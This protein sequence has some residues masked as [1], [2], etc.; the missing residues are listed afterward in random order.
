MDNKIKEKIEKSYNSI[1]V[2]AA[3][4]IVLATIIGSVAINQK[5]SYPF[6]E[7]KKSDISQ[8]ISTTGTVKSDQNVSLSFKKG[9]TI[10]SIKV[11]T[12]NKVTK[13]Q[14]LVVLDSKD[15]LTA[16]SQA[17]AALD[18]AKASY[19]KVS[20][21]A[22]ANSIAVAQSAVDSTQVSLDNVKSISQKNIDSKYDYALT[23]LDDANIKMYNASIAAKNIQ[24]NYFTGYDQD[25]ANVRNSIDAI[26]SA[27]N[28]AK[29]SIDLAQSTK[30]KEDIDS[31]IT[32]TKKSLDKI[33]TGLTT[34]KNSCDGTAYK[35]IVSSTEK[36]SLD[37]QKSYISTLQITVS[38][39][40]N[41]IST[42]KTQSEN[43]I[44]SAEAALSQAQASL[45]NLQS[46]AR[47]EDI[48]A[49]KATVEAAE[50]NLRTAQNAYSDSMIISPIDGVITNINPKIGEVVGAGTT[51]VSMISNNKFQIETYL[52]QTELGKIKVGDAV[53]ATLD[54][55]G[56]DVIFD[57]TI[58]TIDPAATISS[59]ISSYKVA[60]EISND[61][62]R[63]K[64]GLTANITIF[65]EKAE[66][67]ITVPLTS[68]LKENGQNYVLLKNKNKI[69]LKKV[70][71][72]LSD[73]QR[74]QITS[75]LS[76]GENILTFEK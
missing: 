33:L 4:L 65:D 52:S 55:Y 21:G 15:T 28:S 22:T 56:K 69:E 19:E 18:S 41:E 31:A 10:A 44:K 1:L 37:T 48:A 23:V 29:T 26:E 8:S 14:T 76:E 64:P 66:N 75:G 12:G 43:N 36:T 9:G 59:G 53:K 35:N 25:A 74:I 61:D 70:E 71:T 62:E 73:G 47:P 7:I 16:V 11:K 39:L 58:I 63:I 27:K 68:L 5:P 3:S 6:S 30:K 17:T 54:A 32:E 72:G 57:A 67:A 38:S 60:A 20:N 13:G 42:L 46:P 45:T 2:G 51:I 40:E 34:I 49:T 24:T 50:A